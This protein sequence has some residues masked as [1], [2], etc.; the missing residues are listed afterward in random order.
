VRELGRF[1][2][3]LCQWAW[4]LGMGVWC[5]VFRFRNGRSAPSLRRVVSCDVTGF[6]LC[7]EFWYET[8]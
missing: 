7:L 1:L 5:G 6:P 4:E 8:V 2:R 3:Q